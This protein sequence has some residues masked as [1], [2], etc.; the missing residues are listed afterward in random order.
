MS[1][2]LSLKDKII[3]EIYLE[4]GGSMNEVKYIVETQ[5]EYV[6]QVMKHSAFEGVLLPYFGKFWAKAYRV[7][8]VNEAA[9]KIKA[10]GII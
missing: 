9:N 3:R 1:R 10:H 6:A 2:E 5:F 7:Q 8:K 4:D